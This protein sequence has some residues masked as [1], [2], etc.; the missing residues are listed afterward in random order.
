M[1][2]RTKPR[3][4]KGAPSTHLPPGVSTELRGRLEAA[5]LELLALFRAL[6]QLQLAQSLPEELQCLFELDA[7]LAEALW[8]LDQRSA[9]LDWAL[10]T[11]DTLTS[12]DA[13]P[14][15]REDFLQ[16]LSKAERRR[17]DDRIGA[18][19]ATLRPEDAYI[20]V[21][22]RDPQAG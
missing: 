15:A 9:K 19:R 8:A 2:R 20:H 17:L 10:M 14:E 6:D 7:D 22:G 11:R 21:P 1:V 5:R 13:I 16:A 18:V 3:A 4:P 12:I